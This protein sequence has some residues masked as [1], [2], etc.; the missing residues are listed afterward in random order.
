MLA[1][2]KSLEYNRYIYINLLCFDEHM[3]K[4]KT[5]RII[6]FFL[7]IMLG[8]FGIAEC[9]KYW[10]SDATVYPKGVDPITFI[11]CIAIILMFIYLIIK[12]IK[13]E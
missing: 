2:H 10:I 4:E 11:G 8:I 6:A 13:G 3:K 1:K 5:I 7:G 12:E 9:I